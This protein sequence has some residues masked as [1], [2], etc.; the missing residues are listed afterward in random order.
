MPHFWVRIAKAF[1]N[2]RLYLLTDTYRPCTLGKT[3]VFLVRSFDGPS[4]CSTNPN[5]LTFCFKLWQFQIKSDRTYNTYRYFHLFSAQVFNKL[6]ATWQTG[7][8]LFDSCSAV[9]RLLG[10]ES[11]SARIK[12]DLTA[13]H[14]LTSHMSTSNLL[15][16]PQLH[17]FSTLPPVLFPFHS[18]FLFFFWLPQDLSHVSA[19]S[20]LD[21]FLFLWLSCDGDPMCFV[22]ARN[23]QDNFFK[24]TLRL[25]PRC[26]FHS[27]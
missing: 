25:V 11:T 17:I 19:S 4:L 8:F 10:N 14:V 3:H 7:S 12:A 21:L 15:N 23:S 9:K 26:W 6:R 16:L 20:A 5:S 2:I 24:C 27:I 13:S 18:P 22:F 1:E